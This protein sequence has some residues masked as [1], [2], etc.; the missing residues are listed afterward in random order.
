MARHHCTLLAPMTP[1]ETAFFRQ[2]GT[3]I[4]QR[5]KVQD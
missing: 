4:A 5:R 3:R 2:L 1:D